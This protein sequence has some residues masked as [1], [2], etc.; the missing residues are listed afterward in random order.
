MTSDH[1]SAR[2][3]FDVTT[4]NKTIRMQPLLALFAL[5]LQLL[6]SLSLPICLI[7]HSLKPFSLRA[8]F[9]YLREGRRAGDSPGSFEA[10]VDSTN[11]L[12]STSPSRSG[13]SFDLRRSSRIELAGAGVSTV[14]VRG[15]INLEDLQRQAEELS[16]VCSQTSS[17]VLVWI[18]RSRQTFAVA[19]SRLLVLLAE[20]GFAPEGNQT[21]H[22]SNMF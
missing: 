16:G 8:R 6:D 21:S 3:L 1:C 12:Y 11:L 22:S 4:G 18:S 7:Q 9:A 10:E 19:W 2:T 17:L 13:S 20:N 14:R 5:T 15:E